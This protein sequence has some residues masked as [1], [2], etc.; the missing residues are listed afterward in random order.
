MTGVCDVIIVLLNRLVIDDDFFALLF[1]LGIVRFIFK[2]SGVC[3]PLNKRKNSY[4][5]LEQWFKAEEGGLIRSQAT[6]RGPTIEK[7]IIFKRRKTRNGYESLRRAG[8]R[9]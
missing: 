6:V 9:L 7:R 5:P 3:I 1:R 2:A 8:F 4:Y